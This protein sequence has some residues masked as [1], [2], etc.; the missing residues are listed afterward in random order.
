LVQIDTTEERG[1]AGAV[2]A[3]AAR[4]RAAGFPDSDIHVVGPS[5]RKQNL[6]VR[7]R[8]TAP[9]RR[10][11]LLLAHA[12]VVEARREDWSVEPFRFLERDG[13]YYGRGTTDMKD[14]AAC[15][16]STLIE[17]KKAGSPLAR[18]IIFALTADE[19][20]GDSNGVE[21]LVRNR[22]DLVDAE[23][24][25][26]EG[27]GGQIHDGRYAVYNVQAAEKVYLSFRLEARDSGGHSALPK[28]ENPIYRLA[29]ALGRLGSHQFPARLNEVT[30]EYFN[31]MSRIETGEVAKDMDTVARASDETSSLRL[32]PERG[33][34]APSRRAA[35]RLPPSA[36]DAIRRLSRL[37]YYNALVRTTCTATML[38]GGHAENALP[39][40]ARAVVNCRL[41]P[42]DSPQEVQRTLA[43]VIGDPGVSVT[44]LGKDDRGPA[45]PL[46]P[47]VIAA[48]EGVAREMWPGVP[49]VPVM[50]TGA[51]DGRI[52]RREGIPTYGLGAFENIEDNRAHGA[53]ER[54]GVKQF[55][56]EL[57][58]LSRVVRAVS[59]PAPSRPAPY[60]PA[61]TASRPSR[62]ERP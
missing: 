6:V 10:P 55:R 22:R 60:P 16:T 23:Y 53:D 29:S 61:T 27:G 20:G 2:A 43:E 32:D 34:L 13:H 59:S 7:L 40:M 5:E 57:E 8:A 3:V 18:D 21:W 39:Q 4:F 51:T 49:V 50:A 46:L 28:R 45:S 31:R 9:T 52:L 17:L 30:R 38:E 58:F 35:P 12:D 1:T 42:E 36:E 48:V 19:E 33:A 11:L 41:L 54:I 44:A 15:W 62:P 24:C 25:L 47:E 56:E 26:N 14:I 37:P